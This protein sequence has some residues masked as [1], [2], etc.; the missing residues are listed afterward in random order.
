MAA[1]SYS[2]CPQLK[3]RSVAEG[4]ENKEF[5]KLYVEVAVEQ[6]ILTLLLKQVGQIYE[7]SFTIASILSLQ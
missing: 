1:N 4:M 7:R 3:G 6:Q 5:D 2:Y